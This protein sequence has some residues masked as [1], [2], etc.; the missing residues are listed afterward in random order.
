[1]LPLTARVAAVPLAA[2]LLAGTSPA[3]A[4]DGAGSEPAG[5]SPV[6]GVTVA[7]SA[8]RP[9]P[10]APAA[11]PD[12]PVKLRWRDTWL[13]WDNSVTAQTL[14]VGKNYLSADPTYVMSGSIR[15]R[16]YLYDGDVDAFF[17]AGRV[18]VV[19]EFTNSDV[20]TERGETTLSDAILLGAYRRTLAKSPNYETLFT[21]A[22]PI[23][24]FPT[25]KFSIDNGTWLGLGTEARIT[26][27]MP[28]AGEKW[29]VFK[30]LTLGAIAGYNH[31]FTRATNPTNEVLGN[32][33]YRMNPEGRAVP[34]DQ[35]AGAAFAEHELHFNARMIADI[36][37][38]MSLFVE[39]SYRPTWKYGYGNVGVCVQTGECSNAMRIDAPVTYVPVTSFEADVYYDVLDQLSVAFG[40][41]NLSAQ[42]GLDGQRRTIFYSPSAQ[43]YLSVIGHL[44]AIYLAAVGKKPEASGSGAHVHP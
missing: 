42:P 26:Q 12:E 13:I 9:S 23:L 8:D 35:L 34:S 44:D 29:S 4:Q 41:V 25:S 38:K 27:S 1:M 36:T 2:A 31:T 17:L 32:S 18:D 24:T 5:S 14:G 40:Y 15:P 7:P 10:A 37:E 16:Y 22:L 43:F 30:T 6:P 20:T 19:H 3:A 33:L 11:A 39:A 21:G 28:L